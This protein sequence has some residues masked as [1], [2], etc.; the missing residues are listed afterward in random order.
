MINELLLIPNVR[1]LVVAACAIYFLAGIVKGT[2]G[3]GFPTTAVS[4][5]AQMTDARTAITVVIMPMLITNLW[6][7]WRSADVFSVWREYRV[8]IICLLVFIAIFSQIASRIPVAALTAIL[9]VIVVLYA[10]HSLYAKP[11]KFATSNDRIAQWI[12]GVAAGIMGGM[13]SV[14]A[15][16]ILIYLRSK[17]L[18]KDQFVATVGVFLLVGSTVLLLGYLNTGV[19]EQGLWLMSCILVIPAIA[20]FGVGEFIRNRLSA[21]R[22]ERLLLWFFLIMGLNLIRRALF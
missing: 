9:G 8:L 2:L 10:A 19:L 14:W 1:E 7:V 3:I 22:F 13:A 11:L 20:G 17:G 12:V 15:P 6:Q 21:K 16:P 18:E 4:L 5:L